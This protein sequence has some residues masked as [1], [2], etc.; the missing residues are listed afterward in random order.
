M[1]V[2]VWATTLLL[3]HRTPSYP[4]LHPIHIFWPINTRN[5][6]MPVPRGGQRNLVCR[7]FP[8]ASYWFEVVRTPGKR[9]TV[10]NISA[11][12]RLHTC[13]MQ[14]QPS[15][16]VSLWLV[17]PLRRSDSLTSVPA[18]TTAATSEA[19]FTYWIVIDQ[20]IELTSRTV[21]RIQATG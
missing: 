5:T 6:A 3:T 8:R 2:Q 21:I 1:E 7:L 14:C 15:L 17:Q 4:I 16:R 13:H 10:L 19:R 9:F 12:L 20:M 11:I 18:N